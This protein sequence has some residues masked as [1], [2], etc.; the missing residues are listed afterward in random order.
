MYRKTEWVLFTEN[1]ITKKEKKKRVYKV[2]TSRLLYETGITIHRSVLFYL[3]KHRAYRPL[4]S[5]LQDS[6]RSNRIVCFPSRKS[7]AVC[8]TRNRVPMLNFSTSIFGS[9]FENRLGT[10]HRPHPSI[11]FIFAFNR[12]LMIRFPFVGIFADFFVHKG[13]YLGS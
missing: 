9:A 5:F 8:Y 6:C 2:S 3:D 12:F 11:Y 7:I 13:F 4:R 1:I 10:I